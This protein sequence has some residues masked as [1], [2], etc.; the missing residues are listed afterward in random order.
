MDAPSPHSPQANHHL[1]SDPSTPTSSSSS[2]RSIYNDEPSSLSPDTIIRLIQ[3][4]RCSR[5]LRAPLR[6]PCGNAVCRACL[7]PIRKRT[8][9]TYPGNE[10]RKQG[11]TCYWE[12]CDTDCV[13]E[14]CIGDCGG[15]ILL[16][17]LVEVFDELLG[18]GPKTSQGGEFRVAWQEPHGDGSGMFEE[19]SATLDGSLLEGTYDLAKRGQ[20]DYDA[21]GVRYETFGQGDRDDGTLV[22]LKEAI[23]NE[24][25]CHVCYSPIQDPLTTSCGHTFCRLCVMMVTNHSDL[26]PVCRRKL[27]VDSTVR[28][29]PTNKRVASLMATLFPEEVALRC[30]GTT[31]DVAGTDEETTIPLFVNTLALPTVPTF[32]HIF[33]PRYRLMIRRVMRNRKRKFGMVMLNGAGR[34]Q[35]ELGRSRFMQYGTVMV[36]D[37]YEPLPDG[38]SLVIA[39]GKS[40]FKVLGSDIVDGYYV[41][42]IRPVNDISITQEERQ[43]ALETSVPLSPSIT[44]ST[45]PS[46]RERLLET[47]PTQELLELSQAFCRKQQGQEVHWLNS[48]VLL[49]YGGIPDDAARFPW[50]FATVLPIKAHEKYELLPTTSVRQRLKVSARWARKLESGEWSADSTPTPG[51]VCLMTSR[52]SP[53]IRSPR[54]NS[55]TIS[56]AP[57]SINSGRFHELFTVFHQQQ[58]QLMRG[59]DSETYVSQTIV[60]GVFLVIFMVQVA[61]NAGQIYRSRRQERDLRQRT[62]TEQASPQF[63]EGQPQ[64]IERPDEEADRNTG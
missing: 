28:A 59:Q 25:D 11:F 22:R 15:D 29:E 3:C 2:P 58:Q 31:R 44:D 56:I 62:E 10:E 16:T 17:R 46:S 35:G 4:S 61:A 52:P 19:R 40:R 24:L 9:I 13:G 7:P 50:W 21:F 41:G 51:D 12:Q 60:V 49:A 30:E 23:R 34:I 26:C 54:V 47:M 37:R 32:I 53:R 43:E 38:R 1:V 63:V 14:H 6:L 57:S 55:R 27:I 33:E 39:T 20:L 45:S 64:E 5:P 18:A 48:R 42:R 8:G 36:I